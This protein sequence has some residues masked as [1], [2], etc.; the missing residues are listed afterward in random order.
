MK[1]TTTD[2]ANGVVYTP[3]ILAEYVAK[4]MLNFSKCHLDAN[5]IQILDPAIGEAELTVALIREI[6][7]QNKT[8][9]IK[10]TG[11][12]ISAQAV[13]VSIQRISM[14]FPSVALDIKHENFLNISVEDDLF[15]INQ[16]Y[17]FIIANPP[18][19][20]TQILGESVSKQLAKQFSLKG[21]VDI[22][23]AFFIVALSLMKTSGVAG[24]ITSN[25][26]L[27]I[28][29]GK[30]LRKYL[31]NN[32]KLLHLVDFGDTR[33]FDASV[34]PCVTIFSKKTG[35]NAQ[36]IPFTSIYLST[37]SEHN[38]S[39][40]KCNSLFDC[41][42]QNG[43]FKNQKGEKYCAKDGYC[44]LDETTY[45][46]PWVM[47]TNSQNEWLSRIHLN[48]WKT[49]DSIGKIRVGI[50]TTADN[51]FLFS[52]NSALVE[53]EPELLKPLITHRNAGSYLGNSQEV[54]TV[55]YPHYSHEGKRHT[56]DLEQYPKAK[57]Y[58]EKHYEQLNG[59][60]YVLKAKRNW[61]EIW[62]PQKPELW[63]R[64][65]VVFRDISEFPQFWLVNEE[66]VVNGD[67]YWIE[68]DDGV[69]DDIIYLLLAVANSDFIVRYYD[70]K[71]NTKLYSNKRRF[72]SQYVEKFPLPNPQSK[73]AKEIVNLTKS[74]I[75]NPNHIKDVKNQID[76]LVEKA[77]TG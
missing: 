74:I 36:K 20:R 16:K 40:Q 9:K 12:D 18:Y 30:S 71:F 47:T 28:G 17:D 46:N 63:S 27:T 57:E 70:Q 5:E 35:E 24:F 77:F 15:N 45:L 72:M 26:F 68:F 19:I 54:W 11:Y 44:D 75:Q 62:V 41:I 65:K 10:V 55:L 64:R 39:Y 42:G 4:E 53:I 2:K 38:I 43:Y 73:V 49:F 21:K 76:L 34:L 13:S 66:A 25:K 6:F 32:A 22:Y 69:S 37:E 58:L 51:V 7:K 23:Y 31:F 67:C 50:K 1:E 8:A 52:D 29:S 60:T 33:I 59:R 3:Q 48:T 56:Y 14:E 61:Y